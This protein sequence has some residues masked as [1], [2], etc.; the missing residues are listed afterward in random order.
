M[1][2]PQVRPLEAAGYRVITPDLRGFG[3]HP[4]GSEPFAHVRDVEALI[5]SA[6]TVVGNSLGGRVALELALL[7]PD[8]VSRLVLVAPGLPGWEWSEE[9]RAGWAEE[10]DAFDRGDLD[11]AAETSLRMWIDGPTRSPGEVDAG[12]RSAVRAMVLRS[13]RLELD[14]GDTAAR[15]EELFHPPVGDRLAEVRCPTLVLVGERDVPDMRAIAAHVAKSIDGAKLEI[16]R[17]AAHLPSLEQ[18][19]EFNALLFA[20]LSDG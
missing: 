6:S 5:D 1:W 2:E 16:V 14:S 13:Y 4:V 7:R 19:E 18:P 3:E 8:L 12:V 9:V 17:D 11:T 10:G 20:F 15:E